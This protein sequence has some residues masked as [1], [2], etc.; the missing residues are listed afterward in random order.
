MK[1]DFKFDL[2]Q[3]VQTVE[4]FGPLRILSRGKLETI[5][6]TPVVLYSVI[7]NNLVRYYEE[8]ELQSIP[9]KNLATV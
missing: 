2:G 8:Q 9:Q 7:S 5:F 4:G 6:G 1:T 3:Q